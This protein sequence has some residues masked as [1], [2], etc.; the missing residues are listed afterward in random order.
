MYKVRLHPDPNIS[1]LLSIALMGKT[2]YE[3]IFS[4][5]CC[6]CHTL[7]ASSAIKRQQWHLMT[8]TLCCCGVWCVL[9]I[10]KR[11]TSEHRQRKFYCARVSMC[12][13][14]H[15]I[16]TCCN[17]ERH[18]NFITFT[19]NFHVFSL[20]LW[21]RLMPKMKHLFASKAV[22]ILAAAS[23][24]KRKLKMRNNGNDNNGEQQQL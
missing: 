24:I 13:C 18:G 14:G 16:A 20:A 1:L 12:V 17:F 15:I 19:R 5:C 3:R 7:A 11:L 2:L 6:C 9:H 21:W 4:C 8:A 23:A 22:R 10:V